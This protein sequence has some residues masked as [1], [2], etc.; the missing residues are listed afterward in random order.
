M[1]CHQRG[2]PRRGGSRAASPRPTHG[3]VGKRS[4][5]A[6][7]AIACGPQ[8]RGPLDRRLTSQVRRRSSR[9]QGQRT[10]GAKCLSDGRSWDGGA[11]GA[12][13]WGRQ[14]WFGLAGQRAAAP[15]TRASRGGLT[16]ASDEGRSSVAER[17]GLLVVPRL[18][19]RR[20]SGEVLRPRRRDDRRR[21]E[22]NGAAALNDHEC[23]RSCRMPSPSKSASCSTAFW[24][25]T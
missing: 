17:C 7:V 25:G 6:D 13:Y 9:A 21:S 18:A 14:P 2:T 1:V 15:K 8:R 5:V 22:G 16:S 10:I 24:R 19:S 23:A 4:T 12:T 20:S 11:L 3:A